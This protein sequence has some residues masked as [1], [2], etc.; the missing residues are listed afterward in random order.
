MHTLAGKPEGC[1]DGLECFT[2]SITCADEVVPFFFGNVF[3]SDGFLCKRKTPIEAIKQ[4]IG[5]SIQGG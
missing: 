5:S 4:P 3:F 1:T 2:F